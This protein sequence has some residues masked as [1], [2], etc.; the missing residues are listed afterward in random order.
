[1]AHPAWMQAMD[2]DGYPPTMTLGRA[3][4]VLEAAKIYHAVSRI[5]P[6]LTKRAVFEI[7]SKSILGRD[8]EPCEAVV[9]SVIAKHIAREFGRD[10][11]RSR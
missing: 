10:W 3:R 9:D 8:T 6:S 11:M 7:L 5:N 1:M 2:V 4:A